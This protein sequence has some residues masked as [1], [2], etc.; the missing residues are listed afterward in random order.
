MLSLEN[1]SG[2]IVL[3]E[4]QRVPEIFPVLRYLV[5][6]HDKRFLILGSASR[7]LIHQSSESLAGRISYLELT[8]L[9]ILETPAPMRDLHKH[10]LQGGFP[11]AF[12][13]PSFIA[14]HDWLEA[15]IQTF[16]ERD[17][18][19]LGININAGYMRN[20]AIALAHYH[21]QIINYSDI[22]T[23]MGVSHTTVKN[24]VNILSG[25]FMINLSFGLEMS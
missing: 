15:Y 8:P 1:L 4:I 3:D 14:A 13:S 20:I 9:T 23:Q 24:Y 19:G 16:I 10:W 5:D 11:K 7:D 18:S 12:L 22:A 21:A 17:L 25:T 2:L 6:H